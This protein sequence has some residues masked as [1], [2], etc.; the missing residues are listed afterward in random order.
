VSILEQLGKLLAP[1]GAFAAAIVVDVFVRDGVTGVGTPLPQ[2]SQLVLRVLAFV[3]GADSSIDRDAHGG[4]G[5]VIM[6]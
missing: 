6:E 3:V 5:L 4:M 2:L 1:L